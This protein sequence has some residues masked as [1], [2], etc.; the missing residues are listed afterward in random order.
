MSKRRWN[1]VRLVLHPVLV[2]GTEAAGQ[3]AAAI[4]FFNEKYPVDVL[5]VGRGG[6]SAEDLWAFNEEPVVRAIYASRI[7]VI[8]AVGHETDTTLADFAADRRAA[9]PSQAA[10]FAVPDGAEIARQ[11]AGLSTRLDTAR[12]RHLVQAQMRLQT[13]HEHPW[14]RNPKLLLARYMQRT[15]RMTQRLS[16]AADRRRSDLRHRLELA[17]RRLELLNPVQLLYRG[18]SIVEKDGKTVSRAKELSPGDAVC[19]TFADG[20]VSAVVADGAKEAQHGA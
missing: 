16:D 18:F 14:R 15:D 7:P 3:I 1:G 6:G 2:Q 10:E 4:R 11:I 9:T 17:L 20:K 12:K 5:I 19:I 8:S 13:L